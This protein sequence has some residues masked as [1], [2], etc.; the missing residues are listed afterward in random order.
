MALRN[1]EAVGKSQAHRQLVHV[2]GVSAQ[3]TG[4]HAGCSRQCDH[5]R[6][7]QLIEALLDVNIAPSEE[8]AEHE[9]L[10]EFKSME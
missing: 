9:V 7:H 3:D 6:A 2:A 10:L 1:A 4:G 8:R 5:Q